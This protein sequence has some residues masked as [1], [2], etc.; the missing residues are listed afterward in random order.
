MVFVV[1]EP[2]DVAGFY[3]VL[4]LKI[5]DIPDLMAH[6]FIEHREANFYPVLKVSAHQV[7]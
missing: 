5:N 2:G 6:L 3:I 1:V 4:Q 7:C